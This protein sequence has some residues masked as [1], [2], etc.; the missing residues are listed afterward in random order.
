MLTYPTC[1]HAPY[2]LSFRSQDQTFILV[3]LPVKH[4]RAA[5]DRVAK[6]AG[7]ARWMQDWVNRLVPR[8][9]LADGVVADP[10]QWGNYDYAPLLWE[11]SR[12]TKQPFSFPS[13]DHYFRWV[14]VG[15]R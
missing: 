9:S 3:K 11:E 4:G 2:G 1:L 5:Q 14:A 12:L 15:M 13:L 7:I 6:P 10:G 8:R